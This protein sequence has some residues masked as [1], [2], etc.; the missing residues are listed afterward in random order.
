MTKHPIQAFKGLHSCTAC[1][2]E[3]TYH[4]TE[5]VNEMIFIHHL[6]ISIRLTWRSFLLKL[7]HGCQSM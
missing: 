3:G 2:S 6:S 5:H 7:I 4:Q 1:L